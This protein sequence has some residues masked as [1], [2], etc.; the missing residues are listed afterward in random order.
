MRFLATRHVARSDLNGGLVYLARFGHHVAQRPRRP[1]ASTASSMD[2]KGR[3]LGCASASGITGLIRAVRETKIDPMT[4][5]L[6]T[7]HNET[8]GLEDVPKRFC[9]LFSF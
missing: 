6:D 2:A 1:R 4:D 7:C 5:N 3:A 8:T 9:P